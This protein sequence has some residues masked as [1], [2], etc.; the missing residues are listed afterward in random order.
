M[1]WCVCGNDGVCV[2]HSVVM[3]VCV[4][5]GVCVVC[6]LCDMYGAGVVF[7]VYVW[8]VGCVMVFGV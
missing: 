3:M 6:V 7:G 1:W 2:V 5:C 4:V 8:Y